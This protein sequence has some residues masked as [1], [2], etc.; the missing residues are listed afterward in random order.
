MA[1]KNIPGKVKQVY[2]DGACLFNSV[3]EVLGINTRENALILR[4][5]VVNYE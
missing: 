3:L 1:E 5:L 4:K 2:G